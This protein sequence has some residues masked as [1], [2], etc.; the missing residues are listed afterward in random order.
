MKK[1]Q[2]DIKIY[3]VLSVF[4]RNAKFFLIISK[5]LE[6]LPYKIEENNSYLKTLSLESNI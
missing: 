2:N 4:N 3:L 5:C 1:Y 6:K